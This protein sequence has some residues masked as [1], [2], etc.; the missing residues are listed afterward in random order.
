M[1][2]ANRPLR[3]EIDE[4]RR[5]LARLADR[6]E[7]I[8]AR[9]AQ[10]ER[11]PRRPAE[12]RATPAAGPADPSDAV[13]PDAELSAARP[14]ITG[15]S[16]IAAAT[17]P[18][19]HSERGRTGRRPARERLSLEQLIGGRFFAVVGAV[20]VLLA[21]AFF[22]KLAF[23]QGWLGRIGLATRCAAAAGFGALL[24]G[25]GEGLRRRFGGLASA[26]VTAAGLATVYATVWFA[27]GA[28]DEVTA[29]LAILG[30]VATTGLGVVLG[31]V[32]RRSLLSAA[33]LAGG[34][35][36]PLIIDARA[37]SPVFF[38][39]YLLALA[40]LAQVLGGLLGGRFL[41]VAGLAW[42]VTGG[43]GAVA[44]ALDSPPLA[45]SLGFFGL[46]WLLIHADALAAA[47]FFGRWRPPRTMELIARRRRECREARAVGG[48]WRRASR[49][50]LAPK[51][52]DAGEFRI[53]RQAVSGSHF[54]W[55][56]AS[57]SATLYAAF[58]GGLFLG[59]AH[60]SLDWLAPAVLAVAHLLL[61]MVASPWRTPGPGARPNARHELAFAAGAQGAALFVAA[62]GFA[63]SGS[64][65]VAAWIALAVAAAFT[66]RRVRF[67]ALHLYGAIVLSVATARV[68]VFDL[69]AFA[70]EDAPLDVL[71]EPFGYTITSWTLLGALASLGWFLLALA[72]R[73]LDPRQVCAAVA[74][75][76]LVASLSAT[77]GDRAA[78]AFAA[79]AAVAVVLGVHRVLPHLV[80]HITGTLLLAVPL[81]MWIGFFG[82]DRGYVDPV[83]AGWPV[84]L[85]VAGALV[86]VVAAAWLLLRRPPARPDPRVERVREPMAASLHVVLGVVLVWS[87]SVEVNRAALTLIPNDPTARNGAVSL[88][89]AALGV[90]S[91]TAG[92]L[93]EAA[94]L[95]YVGLGLLAAA[96]GKLV[97]FDLA[98]ISPVWRVGASVV[99]G[100]TLLAVAVVYTRRRAGPPDDQHEDS[101]PPDPP[102]DF[103]A[104]SPGGP[105]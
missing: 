50:G 9:A 67:P 27:A 16:P 91:L 5:E 66:A 64:A 51:R 104:D 28:F 100:L 86:S 74:A 70:I 63:L 75:G 40:V 101:R 8:D 31:V 24:I 2:D 61:A 1:A 58:F 90:V 32:G 41:H 77:A 55:L 4:L 76:L 71:A 99:I 22:L 42:I 96:A 44:L 78:S 30:L 20:I 82:V 79:I 14:A 102:A 6:L 47:V 21:A 65:Q 73:R 37:P 84:G 94:P 105:F 85:F 17:Q 80:L 23:D 26:G 98:Q 33:A 35:L 18:R 103:P 38:P 49:V 10:G 45:V 53:A 92:L 81:V 11:A 29:T 52:D 60:P 93:H 34:Y 95:R 83:R 68:F 62:L 54:R 36:A 69:F 88:W 39:A 13:G 89:W 25:L 87:T 97:V 57:V 72:A 43:L 56:I 48:R 19:Q 3:E 12:E 59:D 7:T 46:Y 15:T